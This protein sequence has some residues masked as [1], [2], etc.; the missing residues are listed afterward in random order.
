M[1]VT[2]KRTE[3]TRYY[4]TVDGT[5]LMDCF[6]YFID[7]WWYVLLEYGISWF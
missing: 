3:N 5:H 2:S 1:Y 4:S 6:I 7:K